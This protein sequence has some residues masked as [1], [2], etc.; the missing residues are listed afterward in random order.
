MVNSKGRS[1]M[2][3]TLESPSAN[4]ADQINSLVL[5]YLTSSSSVGSGGFFVSTVKGRTALYDANAHQRLTLLSHTHT[6]ADSWQVAS[7]YLVYSSVFDHSGSVERP[8]S[9][10]TLGW[11]GAPT[12]NYALALNPAVA[13]IAGTSASAP[14]RVLLAA[15]APATASAPV[16][17][18][19]SDILRSIRSTFGLTVTQIASVMLVER[20]TIYDWMD[21]NSMDKMRPHSRE[22]LK[23]LHGIAVTWASKAPLYG[24]FLYEQHADGKCVFDLLTA[25]SLD[26]N[27]FVQAYDALVQTKKPDRR[28]AEQVLQ[29]RDTNRVIGVALKDAFKNFGS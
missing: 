9:V 7:E 6:G 16:P 3:E 8:C 17:V 12:F 4:Y 21:S 18:S 14:E 10:P 25:P 11:S 15:A 19:L 2:T 1:C 23:T 28:K 29:Q 22:R 27:A 13:T 26:H 5:T 20:V 24:K